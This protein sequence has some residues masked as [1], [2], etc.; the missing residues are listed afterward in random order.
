M[1]L[2]ANVIY[3]LLMGWLTFTLLSAFFNSLMDL[4]TKLSSGKIHNGAGASL[5]C[6][7]AA[8]PTLIYFLASKLS[9]QEINISK[10]GVF[11]SA[12]AGL[13]VG[14][15]TIFALKMFSTGVSLSLAVPAL[16]ISMIIIACIFGVI[17]LKE[18]ISWK[19]IIGLMFSFV[20]LFL[21]SSTKN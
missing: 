19:L 11:F 20:G 4:F 3:Y 10:E 21:I 5:I 14:I 8:I 7:F 12:T 2:G 15:A 1:I 9:G 16:R 18:S 13:T 17:L 6:I